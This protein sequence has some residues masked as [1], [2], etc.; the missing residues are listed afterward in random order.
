M[1][2]ITLLFFTFMFY[3]FNAYAQHTFTTVTGP[4]NVVNGSPVTLNINDAVNSAGVPVGSYLSISVTA[5]WV[6][7]GGNPWSNETLINVL[8]SSGASGTM[9]A[10]SGAT[11]NGNPT[12]LTF[13]G[14]MSGIYDPSIDGTLDVVLFQSY[15]GT[16]ANWS[17][18]VVSIDVF[19]PTTP[20]TVATINISESECGIQQ[21]ITHSYDAS[22]SSVDWVE[23][24]YDGNCSA[25]T[26]DTFDS[27]Y[28][29]TEIGLYDSSGF[30]LG[31]ND[32]SPSG[33]LLSELSVSSLPAGTYYIAIAGLDATFGSTSFMVTSTANAS[34]NINVNVLADEQLSLTDT[35]V[36]NA[37]TYF[38]NPVKNELN[39]KAQSTIQN[40]SIYNMLGQE[41]V[42][43]APNSLQSEVS[44]SNLSN[45]AYIVK[46]TIN[47]VTETIRIIKQ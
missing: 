35:Q 1:K 39:L 2:K 29:D 12:T 9:A 17:N 14:D 6:A 21:T 18:I 8:T 26:F 13:E 46:V 15:S 44:M 7:G 27:T 37:F 3:A 5:D 24:I 47:D 45:G 36:N 28:L 4:V 20:A 33:G 34:G 30:L 22:V 43:T 42:R 40:V 23:F 41:V 19:V 31:N 32:D 11:N 10:T 16:S 25:I 38:P